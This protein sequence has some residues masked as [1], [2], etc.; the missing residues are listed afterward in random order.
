[1]D[2]LSLTG[3]KSSLDLPEGATSASLSLERL[4]KQ[5]VMEY[6]TSA[7]VDQGKAY[8]KPIQ[9]QANLSQAKLKAYK[10]TGLG[11]HYFSTSGQDKAETKQKN[12]I[13]TKAAPIP[14]DKRAAELDL[15]HKELVADL[16]MAPAVAS[17]VLKAAS[18]SRKKAILFLENCRGWIANLRK[19]GLDNK[20]VIRGL[21]GSANILTYSAGGREEENIEVLRVLEQAGLR[22]DQVWDVL[23]KHPVV[24]LVR[25]ANLFNIVEWLTAKGFPKPLIQRMILRSPKLL[26][27]S[28]EECLGPTLEYVAWVLGSTEKAVK[29]LIKKPIIFTLRPTSIHGTLLMLTELV[30]CSPSLMLA[31]NYN[32]VTHGMHTR[33]GPRCLI[34]RELGLAEDLMYLS[35]WGTKTPSGFA[36]WPI[37]V[38]AY[39][40]VGHERFPTTN[41]LEEAIV[42]CQERW[43]LEWK[44]KFDERSLVMKAAWKVSGIAGLPT[45]GDVMHKEEE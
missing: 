44:V 35:T 39:Q 31:R 42:V 41:S 1:M 11:S 37:L 2:L 27:C 14:Q 9:S 10:S 26:M 25:P 12:R 21:K 3:S 19:L 16:G 45:I 36:T 4:Y 30:G 20:G 24:L 32:I 23:Q 40:D 34:L 8:F 18:R 7:H 13:F 43:D 29:L 5:H 33:I 17:K 28:P 6:A 38:Q 22:S 15:I